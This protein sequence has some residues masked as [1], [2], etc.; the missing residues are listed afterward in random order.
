VYCPKK[1]IVSSLVVST[2]VHV[3]KSMSVRLSKE[4]KHGSLLFHASGYARKI[5]RRILPC[6]I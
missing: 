1:V 4:L 5:L 3:G 6:F 2:A